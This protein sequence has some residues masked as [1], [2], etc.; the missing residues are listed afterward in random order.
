MARDCGFFDSSNHD[1]QYDAGDFRKLVSILSKNGITRDT[2]TVNFQVNATTPASMNLTV[3][4]G[5]GIVNG[6]W[7]QKSSQTTVNIPTASS[8]APRYDAVVIE[9][10]SQAVTRDIPITVVQGTADASPTHPTLTQTD[11]VYQIPL[12][13][14]KVEVNAT[15]IAQEKIEDV[16]GTNECPWLRADI[17]EGFGIHISDDGTISTNIASRTVAGL[18]KVGQNLRIEEDGTLNALGGGGTGGGLYDLEDVDIDVETLANKDIL[19]YN[20]TAE[21][22]ENKQPNGHTVAVRTL[23]ASGW[24][25]SN[26]YSLSSVYP[27]NEYDIQVA[28]YSAMTTAQLKAWSLAK[29]VGNSTGNTITALGEKP[30][31][32]IP[33]LVYAFKK[34]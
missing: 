22:W 7:I 3:N 24:N 17:K 32:D 5:S 9:F 8:T 28:P 18:V 29:P 25:S 14:V 11:T 6:G 31:I 27:D 33:V 15:S 30:T 12:A 16:R 20:S 23:S 1:R 19:V 10:N 21:K 26:V 34:G 4:G 13:Y 2:S